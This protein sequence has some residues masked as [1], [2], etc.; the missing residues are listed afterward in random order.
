MLSDIVDLRDFYRSSLGLVARRTVQ[1]CVRETWPDVHGLNVL[2]LGYATPYLSVFRHEAKAVMAVM[3]AEM[4][5]LAWPEE[6]ANATCLSQEGNLPLADRSVERILMVH[7][8]EGSRQVPGLLREV[9][10]V[11]DDGGRLLVL[12]PN[13]AGIW[14]RSDR[15]PFG[16]G[17]PFSIGQTNRILR[18]A[19]FT[20]LAATRV[21]YVPPSRR[22][23]I[24]SAAPAI[25]KIGRRW[26]QPLGGVAVVEATKRIYAATTGAKQ[27]ATRR[28]LPVGAPV[29]QAGRITP[30]RSTGGGSRE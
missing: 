27:L 20:P 19:M 29:G 16:N 6:G 5:V 15:T 22:R 23:F 17:Q 7:A 28:Y 4:G 30:R 26:F 18:E 2:G 12:V 10:R 13:R 14:A 21:L 25:E 9:W 11:L 8:L 1:R 24:L 3:P